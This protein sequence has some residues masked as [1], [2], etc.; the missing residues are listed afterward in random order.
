MSESAELEG[1]AVILLLQIPSGGLIDNVFN[2][3]GYPT[4]W[5]DVRRTGARKKI[6]F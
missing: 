3:K 5:I 2:R 1:A 4:G 6:A